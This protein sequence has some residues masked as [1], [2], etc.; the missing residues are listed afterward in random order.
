MIRL[1]NYGL[2]LGV[3]IGIGITATAVVM[4]LGGAGLGTG[5]YQ[6]S[7]DP[8][9]TPPNAEEMEAMIAAWEATTSPNANHVLLATLE[10]QWNTTT[11][12]FM[13]PQTQ[14]SNGTAEF[15]TIMGGRFIQEHTT[16]SFMGE[17]SSGQNLYGYDNF[18]KKFTSVH[19]D[20]IGTAVYLA[21]GTMDQSGK[22]VTY[23]GQMDE[24][25]T[26]E[27]DKTFQLTMDMTDSDRVVFTIHDLHIVPGDTKVLETVYERAQ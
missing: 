24:P 5:I 10:G 14:S 16:G 8:A 13:G 2:S 21:E 23:F 25:M 22:V 3:G 15:A 7:S 20:S 11:T 27:H 4:T 12:M 18:K 9:P 1:K 6:D 26:G 19:F 17:E